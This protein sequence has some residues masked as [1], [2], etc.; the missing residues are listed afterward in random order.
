MTVTPTSDAN[1]VRVQM[2]LVDHGVSNYGSPRIVSTGST[3]EVVVITDAGKQLAEVTMGGRVRLDV[4]LIDGQPTRSTGSSST[5]GT[6]STIS[7]VDQT[8][9]TPGP[10]LCESLV[11]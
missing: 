11:H 7:A 3:R 4:P 1:R 5:S 10:T 9:S 6:P 2:S 8:G